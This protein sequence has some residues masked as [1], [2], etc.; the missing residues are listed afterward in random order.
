MGGNGSSSKKRSGGGG[1][2][3]SYNGLGR[4]PEERAYKTALQVMTNPK[5]RA[6]AKPTPEELKIMRIA[7]ERSLRN[8][9]K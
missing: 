5:V 3:N 7:S 1:A 8:L 6:S 4:T 2:A 9:K